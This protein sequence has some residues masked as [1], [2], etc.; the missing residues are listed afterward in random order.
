MSYNRYDE[1]K[2]STVS[3]IP[4]FFREFLGLTG[5]Y[6]RPEYGNYGSSKR[7]IADSTTSWMPGFFRRWV[8]IEYSEPKRYGSSSE[9]ERRQSSR[10]SAPPPQR[11]YN[12]PPP[13]TSARSDYG[14]NRSSYG[15]GR[16]D[17]VAQ[18]PEGSERM[19]FR[20][21][22]D[23]YSSESGPVMQGGSEQPARF[24]GY[25]KPITYG[26]RGYLRGA[27]PPQGLEALLRQFR[28]TVQDVA[29]MYQK[30][31]DLQTRELTDAVDNWRRQRPAGRDT[32]MTQVAVETG[33]TPAPAASKPAPPPEPAASKPAPTP[34]PAASKPAPTPEPAA[35]KPAPTPEPA[36][37]KPAPTPKSAAD[38]STS[39]K[40]WVDSQSAPPTPPAST[41]VKVE[42]AEPK[43]DEGDKDKEG[44]EAKK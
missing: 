7:E 36:A 14:S 18:R 26:V 32:Q 5:E 9:P 38:Q 8:G 30:A 3:W 2:N 13:P 4:S 41:E 33:E 15:G 37:S 22:S 40:P 35:S 39:A 17:Y 11:S 44:G 12:P 27:L 28:T 43:P 20:S 42:N 21:G 31:F 16:D 23:N 19:S 25:V 1:D 6:R 34:E 10:P 29:G 24:E